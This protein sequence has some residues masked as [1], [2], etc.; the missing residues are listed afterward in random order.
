[1]LA[2]KKRR[3]LTWQLA[4]LLL[5][6][7]VVVGY[8]SCVRMSHEMWGG[9]VSRYHD[10]YVLGS[11]A[12]AVTFLAG[13]AI[14]LAITVRAVASPAGSESSLATPPRASPGAVS[15]AALHQ[16]SSDAGIKG[17]ALVS[18]RGATALICLHAI[19]AA[20][21]VLSCVAIIQRHWGYLPLT[22]NYG[23]SYWLGAV[24]TLL[25]SQLP[26][27]A[28]LIRTWRV[29]DRAG[30]TLVMVA[31]ATQVLAAVFPD[32]RYTAARL[33]PWPWPSAALGLAA[34]ALA[35]LAGRSV[36]SRRSDVGLQVSIFFGF[37]A[38]TVLAQIA[39][40]ILLSRMGLWLP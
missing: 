38:Y 20:I 5:I 33:D 32:L 30:L 13:V 19:L 23:R 4:L 12:G 22:S 28:A 8:P 24:L 36:P 21:I 37:V 26:Y 2:G 11:F 16:L 35:Y 18:S 9:D 31:G 6:F 14:F 25:L 17:Q 29:P 1:M 40:A 34:V 39:L 15:S 27:A 7:G 3:P 10:L